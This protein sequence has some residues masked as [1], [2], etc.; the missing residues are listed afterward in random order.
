MLQD[1]PD[2]MR[3]I[4]PSKI[5]GDADLMARVDGIL[6]R[7]LS[8]APVDESEP[9]VEPEVL[10]ERALVYA[11]RVER[12]IADQDQRIAYLNDLSQTDEL[13]GLL[14][15]RGFMEHFRRALS[16]ARRYGEHGILLFCDLDN[17]KSVNDTYGHATGDELLRHTARVLSSSVRDSDIVGRLGGDEFAVV[18]VQ[19]NWR[20][21]AKRARTLQ[22]RLE[23][24]NPTINGKRVPLAVSMGYEHY[25][26]DDEIDDVVCRADMGMYYAKRLR[27]NPVS[28]AAAE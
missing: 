4:R 3:D 24:S 10:L 6:D 15:R 8:E 5:S 14:N 23:R 18:L 13:T 2:S 1:T 16:S 22:F 21:G 17:F 7:L 27:A 11:A 28:F 25:R 20:D 9:D 26:P 12:R 19:S